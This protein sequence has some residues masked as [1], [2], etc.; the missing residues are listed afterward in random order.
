LLLLLSG[1]SGAGKSSVLAE[2]T[3]TDWGQPVECAEF[4]SVGVPQGADTA[5]RH[6]VIERWVRH[7]MT[8]QAAG[9]HLL[10][11][12]QVPLG[13]LLVAPSIDQVDGVEVCVLHC[14]PDVRSARLRGRGEPEDTLVHHVRFG[15]WFLGHTRDP[16]HSPEVIRV[17]TS[18]A[19]RWERWADWTQGDP[20]WRAHLI[21]TDTL[22]PA[23]VADQ[24]AA[25][26]QEAL[27]RGVGSRID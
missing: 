12:G 10:L 4:D 17:E 27:D 3:A 7:A 14:S 26:A 16:A 20:R 2:L 18:T 21:D 22:T 19:M 15:E 5:W 11:C 6:C 24:V 13:E 25:W 8:L 1:A 23:E 9:A